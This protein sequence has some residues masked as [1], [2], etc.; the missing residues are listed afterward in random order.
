[1]RNELL[2]DELVAFVETYKDQCRFKPNAIDL[3][4]QA[5]RNRRNASGRKLAGYRDY[6]NETTVKLVA[7]RDRLFT[8]AFGYAF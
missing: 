2:T 8:D 3:I 6:Y 4:R 7:D 5:D 1:M